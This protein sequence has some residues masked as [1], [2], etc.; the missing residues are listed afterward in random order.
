MS[1]SAAGLPE[2]VSEALDAFAKE[3][4]SMVDDALRRSANRCRSVLK[5]TSPR[6]NQAK[7]YADGWAVT[8]EGDTLSKSFI[9]HN[10]TKPGLAHLL[11]NGHVGKN[12]HG[13]WGYVQG[14]GHIDKVEAEAVDYLIEQLKGAGAL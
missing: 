8:V 11:N 3:H 4:R 13:Q 10:K 14:D 2:A 12:Q 1:V 6:G 7:H 5:A 9:V